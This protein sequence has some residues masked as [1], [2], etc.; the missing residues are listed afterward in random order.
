MALHRYHCPDCGAPANSEMKTC[1]RCGYRFSDK[2]SCLVPWAVLAIFLLSL[3]VAWILG[4]TIQTRVVI[5][6]SLMAALCWGL[7]LRSHPSSSN[8]D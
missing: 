1:E 5:T 6:L 7:L 2:S 8:D 3:G 4:G